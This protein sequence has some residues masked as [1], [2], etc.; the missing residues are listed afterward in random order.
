MKKI[1]LSTTIFL[2]LTAANA[3]LTN[4]GFETWGG[5]E[6]TGWF[7]ANAL[8][9]SSAQQITSGAPEGSSAL[10]ANVVSCPLC[11]LGGFPDPLPGG[12]VQQVAYAA[13]PATVTFKWKGFVNTGDTSLVGSYLSLATTPVGDALFQ[14]M[15]GTNQTTWQT[16]T[17]TFTYYSSSTPDSI[18]VGVLSDQW[19]LGL[20]TGGGTTGTSVVGTHVDVDD[21]VLAGGT[22]GY[23]L[24][25]TDNAL[26]VA[27]P[28]PASTN[29]NFNLLGTDVTM[30][31]VVDLSGKVVYTE[32]NVL[33]KHVLSL[34]GFVSGSYVV[35]F[36]NNE[37]NYVG[38]A[39][40]N[41]VK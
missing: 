11:P 6:P 19:V 13:R 31:E 29:V 18:M 4:L 10:A 26:I 17:V 7:T 1:L 21:I 3:Q 9:A 32:N 30:F 16:Q 20:L 22:I 39:K 34:D 27:Y 12:A 14:V 33:V 36:F 37:K 15:P 38:S 24:I 40:L 2:S 23:D 25:E 41:V 28:N 35:R 5:G 8:S